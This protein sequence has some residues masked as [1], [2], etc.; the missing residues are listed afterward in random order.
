MALRAGKR[1]WK[2]KKE[3]FHTCG[4]PRRRPGR[5]Q[6]RGRRIFQW[7]IFLW[8]IIY[9]DRYRIYIARY[10]IIYIYTY[11]I[12]YIVRYFYS[13]TK[14]WVGESHEVRRRWPRRSQR[15]KMVRR[16][17]RFGNL[18]KLMSLHLYLYLYMYISISY[19]SVCLSIY[20]SV[21]LSVC[22]S[23]YL[24]I[25]LCVYIYICIYIYT[26]INIFI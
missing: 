6:G 13:S 8:N 11:N 15:S 9:I 3:K 16:D 24:S 18:G 25:Y 19:L 22:L 14:P 1:P 5:G 12:Q 7:D 21:C 23:I 20:L 2:A 26:Y 4:G 10:N 17:G